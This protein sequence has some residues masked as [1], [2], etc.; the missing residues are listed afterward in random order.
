MFI[1]NIPMVFGAVWRVA[2]CFVDERVKAKIRFLRRSEL[3]MLHEFIDAQYLPVSLGGDCKDQLI[4]TR[5][6][7]PGLRARVAMHMGFQLFEDRGMRGV[8][9]QDHVVAG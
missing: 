5:A 6:G 3:H 8:L 9:S 7:E 2:Q 4:S 1:I